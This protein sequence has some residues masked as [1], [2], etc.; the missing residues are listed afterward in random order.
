MADPLTVVPA[1][2]NFSADLFGKGGVCLSRSVGKR[3]IADAAVQRC[4]GGGI[5]GKGRRLQ[6]GDDLVIERGKDQMPAAS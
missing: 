2:V 3:E 4:N 6:M 5:G 1:A